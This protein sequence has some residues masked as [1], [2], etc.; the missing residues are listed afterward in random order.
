MKKVF[1]FMTV[2]LL[3]LCVNSAY[4]Q[5]V[6]LAKGSNYY[7][8]W[9]DGDV[10]GT[11]GVFSRTAGD[12]RINGQYGEGGDRDGEFFIDVWG[13]SYGFPTVQGQGYFGQ[14]G[15]FLSVQSGG[16]GWDGWAGG[17]FNFIP[18]PG[19]STTVDFSQITED[20]RFHIAVRKTNTNPCRINLFGAK[21]DENAASFIVGVGNQVYEDQGTN[22]TPGFVV[23]QWQAINI[24]VSQ[25]MELG[26]DNRDGAFPNTG[27]NAGGYYFTYDFGSDNNNNLQFDAVFFYDPAGNPGS[28][29]NDV[30][31]DN[32]LDVIVTNNVVSVLNATA[33]IEVYNVA[34]VKVK[35]CT[36]PIFG[37][38]EVSPGIYIIK[39][40]NAVAKVFIK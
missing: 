5:Q 16:P 2:A 30:Q 35:T 20:Y 33:P 21:G 12:Y 26:W 6:D 37:T 31:A 13:N 1:Y 40:G 25:L 9:L 18:Q 7:L 4:A 10:D 23:N 34:G 29:I 24:P 14:P 32:K 3:A 39:S 28:G 17:G 11:Y 38:D 8:I 22:L 19:S 15:G 27:E 36:Q